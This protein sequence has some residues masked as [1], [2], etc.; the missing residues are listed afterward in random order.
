MENID[1]KLNQ[2][3]S[4]FYTAYERLNRVAWGGTLPGCMIRFYRGRGGRTLAFAQNSLPPEIS[5]NLS[6]CLGLRE[7]LLWGVMAHEMTHIW[8]YAR[9]RAGGHG[10]DFRCEMLR[11]GIDEKRG[12]VLPESAGDYVFLLNEITPVSLRDALQ[13]IRDCSSFSYE[14][15]TGQ[16]YS[17]TVA[18]REC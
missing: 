10:R 17:R 3:Y 11:I 18:G 14:E 12:I 1:E 13:I 4:C 6:R 5:F 16:F 8:Q 9:G 7:E 15:V 2:A